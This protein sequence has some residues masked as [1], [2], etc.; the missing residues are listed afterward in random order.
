MSADMLWRNSPHYFRSLLEKFEISEHLICIYFCCVGNSD[1]AVWSVGSVINAELA[2]GLIVTS[3][4][5][6]SSPPQTVSSR[7][8][9]PSGP[10]FEMLHQ[11]IST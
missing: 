1:L 2:P 4:R 11:F 9:L 3:R 5:N 8:W 7:G 6:E 10:G